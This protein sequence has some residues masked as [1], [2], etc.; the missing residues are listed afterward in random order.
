MDETT[1][2]N[3]CNVIVLAL[4][5]GKLANAEK[6]FIEALRIR[7]GV[8]ET[9]FHELCVE[10]RKNPKNISLPDNPAEIDEAIRLLVDL[11]SADGQVSENEKQML[12]QFVIK[13]GLDE[14]ELEKFLQDNSE[15]RGEQAERIEAM[16]EEIY[17]GF[18][19]WDKDT[20]KVRL[21]ALG[22]LGQVAAI[23]LLRMFESYR[24]PSG[25][26]LNLEMKAM[27]AEQL[28][29]IGDHR[30]AYYFAQQINLGDME[31]DVTSLALRCASVQALSKCVGETFSPNQEG[32]DSA[33]QWWISEGGKRFN[34][35][36][37]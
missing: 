16:I 13:A 36:A 37:L 33:R 28:G 25:M 6:Q 22:V 26:E 15:A 3:L 17:N 21:D 2:Q 19:E 7:L 5:D 35:L 10:V 11:A 12:K 4:A 29:R 31:D 27:V 32:I 20:K 23:P 24:K 8:D 30:A 34:K 14:A 1:R 9:Q 18:N